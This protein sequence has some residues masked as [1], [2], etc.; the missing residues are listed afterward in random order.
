MPMESAENTYWNHEK[1]FQFFK[2]AIYI[3]ILFNVIFFMV[4]DY[5][6]SAITYKNGFSLAEIGNVFSASVDSIAW[7]ALL[8][9]LRM[10]I[11]ATSESYFSMSLLPSVTFSLLSPFW[12]I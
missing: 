10:N 11:W 9:L 7:Y 8:M 1:L 2:Y 4:E 6:A 12:V 3:L 5:S